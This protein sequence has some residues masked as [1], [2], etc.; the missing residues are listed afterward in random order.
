MKKTSIEVFAIAFCLLA[1]SGMALASGTSHAPR[2]PVKEGSSSSTNWGGYAVTG[3]S[4]SVTD[5]K[6]SWVVPAVTCTS[7][8]QYSSFWVGIDGYS[9][10]TVEQIG[11]SSDCSGATPKYY[12]WAEFYPKFPKTLPLTISPGDVIS[13]EVKYTGKNSFTVTLTDVTTGKSAS[14]TGKVP[15]AKRSSAEWIFEA[16]Y[17]GGVLPLANFGTVFF[18]QDYTSVAP[19]G[20]ATIGSVTGAIGSFGS[21]VQQITMAYSDGTVKASPSN[22]TADGTSFAGVWQHS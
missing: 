14:A 15:S 10:G 3:A 17:S 9:S 13:A 20:S 5:V 11:T 6:G 22:L 4:G 12:A 8:N 2:I 18:G 7:G 16:P 21:S 19:T 1:F